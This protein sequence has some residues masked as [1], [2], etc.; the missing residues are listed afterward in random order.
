MAGR[1]LTQLGLDDLP[2][3][4][5]E[6]IGMAP[7]IS[8]VHRAYYNENARRPGSGKFIVRTG[9]GKVSMIDQGREGEFSGKL[10]WLSVPV[11][12]VIYPSF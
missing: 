5:T 7:H 9:I 3:G 2:G 10:C 12:T 1:E 4:T 8:V 11:I 6:R